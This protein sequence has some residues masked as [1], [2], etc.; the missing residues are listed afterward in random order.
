M[1]KFLLPLFFFSLTAA[2]Q[3]TD[4]AVYQAYLKNNMEVL[5]AEKQ[6]PVQL[7]DAAFFASQLFLFGENHGSAVPLATDLLLF[8]QLHQ[9]AGVRYYMAE[10]DD[11]KAWMLNNYLQTGNEQWLKKVFASWIADT[12]QWASKENEARYRGLRS[13]YQQLPA[14]DKFTI[15]GIDLVQDY[16]LL[17]E[18]VHFYRSGKN[19]A[20]VKLLTDSLAAI[21]DTITYPYRKQLGAYCR[22][23]LQNINTNNKP[24]RQA[25]G[26]NFTAFR[27]TVASFSFLGAGMYRDS[28]MY[29]NFKSL[30]DKYP[31]AGKKLYGFLGY[32]HTLQISYDGRLPF[33]AHLQAGTPLSGKIVSIQMQ[34]IN[35]GSMLPYM[36]QLRQMM[37][38]SFVNKLR[39]DNPYFPVSEKYIPYNLS[40]DDAMMKVAGINNLKAVSAPNTATLFRLSNTGSPYHSSRQ[41]METTGFQTLKPT[42][43]ATFTTQAFQY[44]LLYRNSPAVLPAE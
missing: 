38:A 31:L 13:F 6:L 32:Y 40:N 20:A 43:A 14:K 3:V 42:S 28:V 37:P 22:R 41:L 7:F 15:L 10:V 2:A 8:K 39:Q 11:T 1:K 4:S 30:A 33:A 9:K 27:H 12:L 35:C 23:L 19:A 16:S 21:T 5:D 18:Q 26:S 34:A 24:Y 36:A 44:V 29:R 25:L 17:K